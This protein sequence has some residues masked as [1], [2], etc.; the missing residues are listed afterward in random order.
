MGSNEKL[1]YEE[2]M[3]KNASP[4]AAYDPVLHYVKTLEEGN[5]WVIPS[6]FHIV[7]HN[8]LFNFASLPTIFKTIVIIGAW[9]SPIV[10]PIFPS[11]IINNPNV[12][13]GPCASNLITEQITQ[14]L[15]IPRKDG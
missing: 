13:G 6:N 4:F 1:N 3:E 5:S 10:Q 8:T 2:A 12:K 7:G 15:H 11:P 14:P 9:Q